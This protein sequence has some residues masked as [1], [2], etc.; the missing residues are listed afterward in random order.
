MGGL[1]I[2][3][4]QHLLR[5]GLILGLCEH[6]ICCH[7]KPELF[8][9]WGNWGNF[10]PLHQGGVIPYKDKQERKFSFSSTCFDGPL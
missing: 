10:V 3:L 4:G 9:N 8:R 2:A 1:E 6:A 5:L 7:L